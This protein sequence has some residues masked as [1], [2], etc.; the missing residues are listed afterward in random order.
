MAQRFARSTP[1]QIQPRPAAPAPVAQAPAPPQGAANPQQRQQLAA[2]FPN[3]P[4]IQAAGGGG[5]IG[6]LFG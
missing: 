6:S 3:D 4:I 5:G 1:T 2:M